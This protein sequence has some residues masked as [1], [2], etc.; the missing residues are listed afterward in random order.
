MA[1]ECRR[2]D[3]LKEAITNSDDVHAT[4]SYC[5]NV[6]HAFVNR[7]EYRREVTIHKFADIP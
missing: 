6:S 7:R 4:L 2:L 1:I 5:M 3:K